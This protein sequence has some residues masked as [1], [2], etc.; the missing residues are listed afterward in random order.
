MSVQRKDADS[1]GGDVDQ[2][3]LFRILVRS[4]I[5]AANLVQPATPIDPSHQP[6]QPRRSLAHPASLKDPSNSTRQGRT[7]RSAPR[8]SYKLPSSLS[9]FSFPPPPLLLSSQ[10]PPPPPPPP[11]TPSVPS[12]V[13]RLII[14][15]RLGEREG[16]SRPAPSQQKTQ[17]FNFCFRAFACF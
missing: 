13:T 3:F 5:N 12:Y 2:L 16:Q 9:P 17:R 6:L 10:L 15:S 8:P 7:S 4:H 1:S 14:G 11:S